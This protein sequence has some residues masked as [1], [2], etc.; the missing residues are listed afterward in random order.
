MYG[1]GTAAHP[2]AVEPASVR[3]PEVEARFTLAG[4]EGLGWSTS[5]RHR[6]RR[7]EALIQTI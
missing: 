6:S 4:V 7:L 3:S 5:A 1:I 2:V